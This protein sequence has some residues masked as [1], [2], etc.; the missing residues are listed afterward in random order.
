M[1]KEIFF[2]GSKKKRFYAFSDL[3]RDLDATNMDIDKY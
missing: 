3:L 1:I 2:G